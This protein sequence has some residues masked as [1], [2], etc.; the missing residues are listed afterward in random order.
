MAVGGLL[1]AVNL[2]IEAGQS[3]EQGQ[4]TG[5][6]TGFVELDE[7]TGGLHPGQMIDRGRAPRHGQVPRSPSTSAAPPRSTPTARTQAHPQLLL[8][9]EMGAWSS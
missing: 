1:N 6:P 8:L 2:E 3:R 9:P 7:L 5:V 4:M